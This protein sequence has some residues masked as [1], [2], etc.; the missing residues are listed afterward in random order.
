[1]YVVRTINEIRRAPAKQR[2]MIDE[3]TYEGNG[4]PLDRFKIGGN[5]IQGDSKKLH[6]AFVEGPLDVSAAVS[7]T[8]LARFPSS[9]GREFVLFPSII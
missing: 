7:I 1:M 3:T 4:V 9:C 6:V 2:R 5:S 8:F